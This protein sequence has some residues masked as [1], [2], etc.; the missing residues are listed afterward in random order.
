MKKIFTTLLAFGGLA[1]LML[2]SC[3][4]DE[5]KTVA[6]VGKVGALTSTTTTPVL[7]KPNAAN[8][9]IT[10][11]WAATPVTGYN[12]PVTYTL[13]LDVKGD[14]FK[15]PREVSTNLLTKTI[16][17][18]DLNDMLTNLKV[19]F[20]SLTDIEV[21]IKSSAAAN[22]AA[23]YSNTIVLSTK[24]YQQVGYLYVPGAYQSPDASK[25]WTP[26]TADSLKSPNN[27]GIYDGVIPFAAGRLDFKIT[28]TKKDFSGNLGDGGAGKLSPTGGNL[29][30]PSAGLYAIHVDLNTN[31]IT[32]RQIFWSIIGDATPGGWGTDTDMTFDADKNTWTVTAVL[33]AGK[34]MKF[35]Y[36]HAWDSNLGGTT[37]ALTQNGPNIAIT[38]GGTFK[39]VLNL[40][41]NTYTSTKQ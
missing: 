15:T 24:P 21:R 23:T 22:L 2:T 9:A 13:Q 33:I 20:T 29:S 34:E 37:G 27:D 38:T 35:R 7:T 1:L 31:T 36:D 4:K 30:A 18:S 17:V 32:F 40:N 10:F 39:I 6:N 26:G 19:S 8:D 11:N 12:V 41:N 5:V 14:N 28:P 3:K 16:K 25:Q